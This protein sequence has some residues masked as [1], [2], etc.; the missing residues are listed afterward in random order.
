M[1]D[2]ALLAIWVVGGMVAIAGC[3]TYVTG[4]RSPLAVN[5]RRRLNEL[6]VETR[7]GS[8]EKIIAALREQAK[9]YLRL[10]KRWE[11][12]TVLRRALQLA[13]QEY[14]ERFEALPDIMEDF[15]R[16]M[17]SMHR[18]KEAEQM[19]KEAQKARQRIKG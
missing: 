17:D 12:E 2:A 10:G 9:L 8:P 19:R 11:A 7:M 14:G 1:D 3:Y 4:P 13:R 5:W 18:K 15:A 6:D 16:V